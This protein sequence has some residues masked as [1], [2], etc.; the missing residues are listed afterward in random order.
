MSE[1]HS[2]GDTG[3]RSQAAV[4]ALS[5]AVR[6]EVTDRGTGALAGLTQKAALEG[7]FAEQF[8]VL[9]SQLCNG[10]TT[11]LPRPDP[12]TATD[13]FTAGLQAARAAY[14]IAS[15]LIG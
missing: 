6:T 11:G 2:Y 10:L 15:K 1:E 8:K 7:A 5:P 4:F 12:K 3:W 9:F 14:D 13:R